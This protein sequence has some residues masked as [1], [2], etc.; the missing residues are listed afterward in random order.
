MAGQGRPSWPRLGPRLFTPAAAL[1]QEAVASAGRGPVRACGGPAVCPASRTRPASL[2][3]GWSWAAP[4]SPA[5]ST[6]VPWVPLEQQRCSIDAVC[7]GWRARGRGRGRGERGVR[8]MRCGTA[9]GANPACRS[10]RGLGASGKLRRRRRRQGPG[11]DRPEASLKLIFRSRLG[12][13]P[14]ALL[15][16]SRGVTAHGVGSG[17]SGA[18]LIPASAAACRP[19]VTGLSV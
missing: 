16:L 15:I 10:T 14:R 8:G 17:P 18:L 2:A 1:R 5:N 9:G 11:R 19:P 12:V 4:P 13:A 6:Y 7:S 3:P